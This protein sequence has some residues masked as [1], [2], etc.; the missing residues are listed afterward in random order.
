MT[1]FFKMIGT[2]KTTDFTVIPAPA[3]KCAGCWFAGN[4]INRVPMCWANDSK[5]LVKQVFGGSCKGV[6][7]VLNDEVNIKK[8][9]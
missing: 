9:A 7:A 5:N 1:H 3:N 2:P 8:T 6:I 4:S